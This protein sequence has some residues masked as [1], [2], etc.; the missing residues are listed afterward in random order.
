MTKALF[1]Y[2]TLRVGEALSHLLPPT[3]T[4]Y[5][6]SVPGRLA[7]APNTTGFPVLLPPETASDRVQGELIWCDFDDPDIGHVILMEL[8]SGYHA[9]W[10]RAT[11]TVGGVIRAMAFTWNPADAHGAIIDHGDW[12][13][14]TGER[15][16]RQKPLMWVCRECD[17]P[18]DDEYEALNCEWQ[19]TA[20]ACIA[21]Y[22]SDP[23]A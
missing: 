14:L 1:V 11:L 4:R 16:R 22:D 21:A 2:G 17:T 13:R 9:T 8:D 19:H 20:D 6:C 23:T 12:T 18:F 3:L 5:G 7:Y 15:S 10:L